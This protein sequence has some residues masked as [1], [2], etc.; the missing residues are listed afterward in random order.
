M[1]KTEL[2]KLNHYLF[3]IKNWTEKQSML[4]LVDAFLQLNSLDVTKNQEMWDKIKEALS[5]NPEFRDKELLSYITYKEYARQ[6]Y[7]WWDSKNWLIE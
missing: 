2:E 7:W 1:T 3:V 6:G 5:Q 4:A